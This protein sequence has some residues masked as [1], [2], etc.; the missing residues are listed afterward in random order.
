MKVLP[1][2]HHEAGG[3]GDSS[4]WVSGCHQGPDRSWAV[5]DGHV[6]GNGMGWDEGG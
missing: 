4:G 2:P 5:T 3:C 6:P 1:K